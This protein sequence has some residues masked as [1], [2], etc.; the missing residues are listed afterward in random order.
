[1]KTI[2]LKLTEHI[3]AW[4]QRIR[5]SRLLPIG[6]GLLTAALLFKESGRLLRML[7]STAAA[8]DLGILSFPLLYSAYSS[9]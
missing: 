1:M 8:I 9:S 6:W 4:W 3:P 7:D 2:A 5:Q